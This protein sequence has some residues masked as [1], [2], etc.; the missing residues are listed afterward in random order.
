MPR[1]T[2]TS[3]GQITVP[4]EVRTALK[5]SQG[6]Q[7]QI[8]VLANGFEARVVRRPTA[9][10]LQG[11]LK[12]EVPYQGQDAEEQAVADSLAEKFARQE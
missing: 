1:T 12:S 10:S 3:K 8:E 4:Q 2:L 11:I 6:D 5:L 7:L 9:A